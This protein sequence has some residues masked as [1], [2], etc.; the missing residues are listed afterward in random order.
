MRADLFEVIIERPRHGHRGAE[1]LRAPRDDR[2]WAPIGRGR[3]KMLNENLAPLARWLRKQVGRRWDQV[4]SEICEHLSVRSAVQQ[5]VR[6]H[7]GDFVRVHAEDPRRRGQPLFVCP[8]TGLLRAAQR[9]PRL[10]QGR[11]HE[12][13]AGRIALQIRQRWWKIRLQPAKEGSRDALVARLFSAHAGSTFARWL[14]YGRG[15]VQAVE[16]E[17]LSREERRELERRGL[18]RGPR[19]RSRRG[20]R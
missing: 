18:I 17:P 6:D 4:Y 13:G 16:A 7:L 20:S 3:T 10:R 2:S 5:H 12:L 11:R 8:R 19:K 9:P 15:D 14:L 1:K